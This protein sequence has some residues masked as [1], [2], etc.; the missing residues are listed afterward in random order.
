MGRKQ[1]IRRGMVRRGVRGR[2]EEG[3]EEEG[4]ESLKESV[5]TRQC[6]PRSAKYVN[7]M[8]QY[9]VLAYL[10]LDPVVVG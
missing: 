3:N 8:W 4:G 6:K 7:C 9:F 5:L 10:G 2:C 1:E